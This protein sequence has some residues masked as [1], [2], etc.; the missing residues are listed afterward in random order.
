MVRGRLDLK[1]GAADG[2]AER[3][4]QLGED[5][6]RVG[7]GF[8]LER[9]DDLAQQPVVGGRVRWRRPGRRRRH[10]RRSRAVRWL[11]G[12]GIVEQRPG[13]GGHSACTSATAACAGQIDDR[14]LLGVDGDQ[15]LAGEVV[16]AAAGSGA[17]SVQQL[18]RAV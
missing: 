14:I 16:S 15:R 12:R 13:R 9:S 3:D 8:G 1:V 2:G 4:Q 11:L 7:L 18:E 5:R 6:E 10:S 17:R